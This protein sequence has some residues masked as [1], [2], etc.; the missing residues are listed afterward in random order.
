MPSHSPTL[1][2]T[3]VQKS[4]PEVGLNVDEERIRDHM[5]RPVKLD[6]MDKDTK[7]LRSLVH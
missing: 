6:G 7:L 1:D 2:L 5:P 4:E 3:V